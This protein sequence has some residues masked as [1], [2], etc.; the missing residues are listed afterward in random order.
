M[1]TLTTKY[2]PQQLG[3]LCGQETI[4]RT[5]TNAVKQKKIAP[6]YLFTG[7]KG[8]GKTSAA[9][10]LAKSLNC[11][12]SPQPTVTPC[13]NCSSCLAI[14]KSC[15][16]DVTEIDAASHNGVDD[17]RQLIER[18]SLAPVQGRYRIWILDES[19]CLTN[20]AMN[21]LLKCLE[22]PP[23][24]VVFI[25]CTTEAHKLLPTI[26]SRCQVLNFRSLSISA[27]VLKLSQ[28]ATDEEID[29][30]EEALVAIARNAEGG[31]RDALGLLSQ[32]SL[33]ETL[34][35]QSHVLEV[36]GEIAQPDLVAI[37][38]AVR[39]KDIF[40]LLKKSRELLDSGFTP[41]KII[42][43]LIKVY[44]DLVIVAHSPKSVNLTSSALGHEQITQLAASVGY[45]RIIVGLEQLRV[46]SYQLK[47]APQP[48][49][50]LEVCLLGLIQNLQVSPDSGH[51]NGH[52]NGTIAIAPHPEAIWNQVLAATTEKNRKMLS[53]AILTEISGNS[54]TL[55][56][57][58][59]YLDKFNRLA[60]KI[61]QMLSKVC[62]V[63]ID[64]SIEESRA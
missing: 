46:S 19:H 58:K 24:N 18:S 61:A 37:L 2:R 64:L 47:Q 48:N 10:I 11:L 7:S 22:E 20:Q 4:T 23:N 8:T 16:L 35:H 15:S 57:P 50:W 5:L 49:L 41:E 45:D 51:K 54:A 59:K 36:S 28:I 40:S 38:Q 29:I 33:L 9:R 53:V 32:L 17:A 52:K 21:A 14:E 13:G 39:A 60:E 62:E 63:P 44:H 34:I 31:L 30:T 6:A 56:V 25:L 12:N 1:Q 26:I 3:D 43:S 27:I 42:A 55:S